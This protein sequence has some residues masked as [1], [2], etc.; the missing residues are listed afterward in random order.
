MIEPRLRDY[1]DAT[2]RSTS[3]DFTT[4]IFSGIGV[5]RYTGAASALGDVYIAW[6]ARGL[7]AVRLAGDGDAFEAWYAER[8]A[9]RVVP[10]VEDDS[11]SS[12]ARAKLHGE[13]VEVPIDLR[14]CSPF[15]RR[16]LAKAAEISAG[17]A[18]PYAW[19]A[20]ELG[21]PTATRAVGN[22]LGRNPVPLLV[23]C[24]RVIR[25]DCSVGG[26]VFGA[27]TKRELLVQE[28]VDFD[29]L[30]R[31]TRR[32]F[33]YVG[34][35]KGWFCLPTCG[36]VATLVDTPGYR[37]LRTAAEAHARGLRPCGLCRPIAA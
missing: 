19:L 12:A 8:F 20:R 6:S 3:P 32:G 31:I 21:T 7:S 1:R 22:A 35:D 25:T 5:D 9:C 37:L 24:H 36:D 30:E 11:I 34:C 10:A 33:R 2:R 26:Y 23:P 13:D 15:E 14:D 4:K 17:S 18:R 28:G 29:A 27:A 16:V